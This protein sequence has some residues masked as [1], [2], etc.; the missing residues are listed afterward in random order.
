[1]FCQIEEEIID[2]GECEPYS[3]F[4]NIPLKG[5]ELENIKKSI[6]DG[7][8]TYIHI[9]AGPNYTKIDNIF[10]IG[11]FDTKDTMLNLDFEVTKDVLEELY[12]LLHNK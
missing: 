10:S 5:S 6:I 12:I 8:I 11:F 4:E 1:M 9:K 3:E 2:D 7:T